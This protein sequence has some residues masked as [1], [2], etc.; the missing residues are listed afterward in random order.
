MFKKLWKWMSEEEPEFVEVKSKKGNEEALS[1]MLEL[2]STYLSDPK[3]KH[4]DWEVFIGESSRKKLNELG[5][6][7]SYIAQRSRFLLGSSTCGYVL[8]ESERG[9]SNVIDV[10]EGETSFMDGL[11]NLCDLFEATRAERH[12]AE[13]QRLLARKTRIAD[14]LDS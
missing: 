3:E 6:E 7:N 12:E 11:S 4:Y 8:V 2:A 10:I 1:D 9:M 5:Y 13:E 14:F